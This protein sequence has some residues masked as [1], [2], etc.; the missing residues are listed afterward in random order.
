[1]VQHIR[2]AIRHAIA[3]LLQNHADMAGIDIYRARSRPIGLKDADGEA[4]EILVPTESSDIQGNHNGDVSYDRLIDV[5]LIGYHKGTN[6]ESA[7]DAVDLLSLKLETAMHSTKD[8]GG[9][10]IEM[11][12]VST[13]FNLDSGAY[14]NASFAQVWK[15]NCSSSLQEMNS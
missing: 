2:T 1:M 14:A 9:L 3:E 11:N 7:T 4:V 13:N 12:L 10:I 5:H 8:L 15:V 6:G